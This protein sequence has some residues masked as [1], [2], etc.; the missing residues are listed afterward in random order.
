MFLVCSGLIWFI[1]NLSE[2]YINNATFE[3]KFINI[4]DSLLLTKASKEEVDV[5]V[6]ANGFQFLGFNLKNKEV[7][8]DL[9][10]ASQKDG[11][12]FIAQ[13]IYRKQID[14]QLRSMTLIEIDKDT[15]FFEFTQ[16]GTKKVPVT[17]RVGIELSQNFILDGPLKI[18]PAMVTI[19]GP[20]TSI[21]T[22]KS[23]NTLKMSFPEET[24][25]FTH[26]VELFKNPELENTTYSHNT[27]FV[28]GKV[29]RFS[30]KLIDIPIKVVNLPAGYEIR[31]FPD[32]AAVICR[33][34]LDNLKNLD[35]TGFEVVADYNS[36]T[37]NTSKIITLELLKWPES[38]HSA[39]LNENQ[40]EFILKRQ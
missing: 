23:V 14:K 27:V 22:I 17:S 36:V 18:K 40:V 25:N 1:N 10:T 20:K 28:Y 31:T 35:S 24:T 34:K 6:Q 12:Y 19:R 13:S 21:D 37:D 3:F 16:V 29:A 30:E 4:P 11:R 32:A 8:I 15:L 7:K 5:K 26:E 38:L 2:S 9:S 33:A 39:S